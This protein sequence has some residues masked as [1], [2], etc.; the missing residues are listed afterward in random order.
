MSIDSIKRTKPTTEK[1]LYKFSELLISEPLLHLRFEH[2]L[3]NNCYPKI[4]IDQAI[5]HYLKHIPEWL[6][7][8]A[9]L[10][11][12]SYHFSTALEQWI[13]VYHDKPL[14]LS[15]RLKAVCDNPR[16]LEFKSTREALYGFLSRLH[17]LFQY[18]VV[19]R[20]LKRD[21]YNADENYRG[22][23]KYVDDLF[24]LY[25]RL[26]V[27][28]VDFG[29]TKDCSQ[30][31]RFEDARQH[32]DNLLNNLRHNKTFNHLKG[33]IIKT[34]YGLEKKIH[35]HTLWF[36]NGHKR[37]GSSDV[38]LAQDIGE[39]WKNVTGD[40]GTYWNCNADK[41]YYCYNGIGLVKAKDRQKRDYL[42]L[43]IRYLCK[44]ETQVI[45]PRNASQA[46]TLMR[47]DLRNHNPNLGR[48]RSM[49][50]NAA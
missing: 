47:M 13:A 23:C 39:Y 46:K 49:Y 3:L 17:K 12:S 20:A 29:Y 10:P 40:F 30:D 11:Y 31:V 44:K 48:P 25:A 14:L 32:L 36:F 45:K 38:Q 4:E 43:P 22:Y 34:E 1:K 21:K 15:D 37:L 27:V 7:Y 26:V 5:L 6:E 16:T 8:I 2:L 24:S 33:Y 42:Y 9:H 35:F 18:P 28:R 50:T 41:D 19:R